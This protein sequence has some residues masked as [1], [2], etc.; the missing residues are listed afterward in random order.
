LSDWTYSGT[1]T[2]VNPAGEFT[3]NLTQADGFFDY[4]LVTFSTGLNA[5]G[6]A[7]EIK[8]YSSKEFTLFLPPAFP[9]AVGDKFK[10]VAGCDGNFS[11][12][13]NRFNNVVNFRGEPY[14]PGTDYLMSYPSRGSA[15]TV[16]A[17]SNVKR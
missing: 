14:V 11:T 1:V 8:D 15:N 17:G 13:K 9:V 7:Y 4:G 3:T 12:C 5:A 6:L 2:S 16:T 10:A